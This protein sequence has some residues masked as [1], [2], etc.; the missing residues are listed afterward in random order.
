MKVSAKGPFKLLE[1]LKP[2]LEQ[3]GRRAGSFHE[4]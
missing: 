4:T 3:E 1:L 2:W